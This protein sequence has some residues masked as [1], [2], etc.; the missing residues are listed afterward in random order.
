MIR[1][2][3]LKTIRITPLERYGIDEGQVRQKNNDYVRKLT[4]N[5][6]ALTMGAVLGPQR[7]K[8]M[9]EVTN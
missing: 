7:D 3:A 1:M 2:R 9:R 8:A 5:L 6:P 4:V